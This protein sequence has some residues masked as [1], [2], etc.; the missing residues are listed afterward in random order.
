MNPGNPG[1]PPVPKSNHDPGNYCPILKIRVHP[2]KYDPVY[3]R[4][5]VEKFSL[6]F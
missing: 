1:I 5:P 2:P 3:P 4:S 6:Q